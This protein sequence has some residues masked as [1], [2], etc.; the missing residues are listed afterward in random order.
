MSSTPSMS[1]LHSDYAEIYLPKF[2]PSSPILQPILE[3][4]QEENYLVTEQDY[5]KKYLQEVEFIDM[6]WEINLGNEV[7]RVTNRQSKE[8]KSAHP[9]QPKRKGG[10]AVVNNQVKADRVK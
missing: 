1:C 3:I 8:R 9:R 7:E 4:P 5:D 10:A 6:T 2:S